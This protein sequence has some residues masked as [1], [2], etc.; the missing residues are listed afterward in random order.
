MQVASKNFIKTTEKL[1]FLDPYV[2][3]ISNPQIKKKNAVMLN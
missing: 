2:L 3:Y 1:L